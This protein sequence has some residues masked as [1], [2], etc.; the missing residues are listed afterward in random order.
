MKLE[1]VWQWYVEQKLGRLPDP[2]L[3][4][5]VSPQEGQKLLWLWHEHFTPHMAMIAK[6]PHDSAFDTE[7]D[8]ALCLLAKDDS[9]AGWQALSPGAWRVL[10]DRL[11]ATQTVFAANVAGHNHVIAHLPPGLGEAEASRTLGLMFFL[12]KHNP[13]LH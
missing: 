7:A 12:K 4:R 6:T 10:H 1:D 5:P 13:S 8:G 3:A 11:V 2:S 9:F